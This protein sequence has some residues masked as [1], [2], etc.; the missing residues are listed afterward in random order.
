MTNYTKY[1]TPVYVKLINYTMAYI[2]YTT[3]NTVH[4]I[5]HNITSGETIVVAEKTVESN[6]YKALSN[7]MLYYQYPY[8]RLFIYSENKSYTIPNPE[9]GSI[10]STYNTWTEY[11]GRII[12]V[13]RTTIDHYYL[14]II[15]PITKNTTFKKINVTPNEGV[16]DVTEIYDREVVVV[17]QANKLILLDLNGT[18]IDE[19]S[20]PIDKPVRILGIY[21][22][23]HLG[24][25]WLILKCIAEDCYDAY[26][27]IKVEL[28]P[29]TMSVETPDRV[30]AYKPVLFKARLVDVVNDPVVGETIELY[31]IT[32]G[33]RELLASNITDDQGYAYFNIVLELGMHKLKFIYSGNTSTGY[34]SCRE[35]VDVYAET[36]VYGVLG[37]P[38]EVYA[39]FPDIL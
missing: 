30:I 24:E 14:T 5:Y 19:Q 8:W 39:G 26:Y 21:R 20:V 17:V 29:T 1:P 16:I 36:M 25:E 6:I 37:G 13:L 11:N 15:D 33:E 4:S 35:V 10:V 32:S 28:L 9:N 22:L 31:D 38:T 34:M 3:G 7:Y 2:V 23:E 18:V 27:Y 12:G